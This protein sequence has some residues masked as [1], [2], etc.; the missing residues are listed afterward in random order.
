MANRVCQYKYTVS[1]VY[2][3]QVRNKSKTIKTESIKFIVIDHNYLKNSM[4]IVYVNLRLDKKLLDDMKL[5]CN[6]N[7]I[8]LAINKYDNLTNEKQ[9]I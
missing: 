4:P 6:K 1:M 3:D 2:L 8:V 7:L 5:N 9:E